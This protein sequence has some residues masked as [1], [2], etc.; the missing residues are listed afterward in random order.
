MR[1]AAKTDANQEEV[2]RALRQAGCSVLSLAAIGR[3]CPDLLAYSLWTK[4]WALLEV[5]DGAKY[6]SERKLTPAQVE[7]HAKWHGPIHVVTSPDEAL[8]AMG[9]ES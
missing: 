7:F 1:R 6:P 3:G 4:T 8:L 5:K 9:I 2:V